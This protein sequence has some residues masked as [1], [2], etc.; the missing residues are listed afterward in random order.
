[1]EEVEATRRN[2]TRLKIVNEEK[3]KLKAMT[4]DDLERYLGNPAG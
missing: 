2:A 4:F 3:A 1:V